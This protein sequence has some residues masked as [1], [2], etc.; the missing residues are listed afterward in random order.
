MHYLDTQNILL[1]LLQ[2]AVLL[3]AARALGEVFRRWGQP[4]ITAEILVGVLLGPTILGR[5]SPGVQGWLFPPDEVQQTMLETVA[6]LGILFFLLRT[7]L[8]TNLAAAWRQKGQAVTISVADLV[9]PMVVAFVPMLL[10]HRYYGLAGGPEAWVFALFMATIMTIS[11]LPVTARVLHDLRMYRTDVGLLIMSALTINDI[12]GWVVFALILGV[13]SEAV[14]HVGSVVFILTGTLTFSVL[15]L[16]F[17]P[18]LVGLAMNGM[19][20]LSLPE[21]AASLTLTVVIGLLA[22]AATTWI[23]IHA[24]FGFF[25]AGIMMGD[26]RQLPERTRHVFSQLVQALLVPIFFAAIA[27]KVDFL[28]QFNGLLLLLVL[29]IGIAGRFAGAWAG[30]L[31]ARQP[32][33]S[34]MLIA[35]SHIPGGEMQIVIGIL[36]LE[37]RVVSEKVFVAIVAGAVLSSMIAGPWMKHAIRRLRRLDWTELLSPQAVLTE[38]PPESPDDAICR[39]A[40]LAAAAAGLESSEVAAAALQREHI[41]STAMESGVA[42]PHARLEGLKQSVVAL[43]RS[44]QGVDWNSRDAKPANW[45]F[46]VL[47]PTQAAEEQLLI[48]RGI[49]QV[50]SME[51]VRRQLWEA[52]DADQMVSVLREAASRDVVRVVAGG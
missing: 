27:L 17:G 25:I 42:V 51:D 46:L 43:G 23:G 38:L 45:I 33:H 19:S 49:A 24:L 21:P 40:Q 13:F 4:A 18:R 3:G 37:A 29:G 35:V 12:A 47:T 52:G 36:A 16:K 10:L 9:I 41:M 8:E 48:L 5:L 44:R 39:L 31:L 50:M 11:A 14:V 7:G 1:F 20:R 30:A 15:C 32:A 34:R 22:G 26:V 6:W 28:E 2:M